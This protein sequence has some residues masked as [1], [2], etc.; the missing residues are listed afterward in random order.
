M[1]AANARL[2]AQDPAGASRILEAVTAR[3]PANGRAWRLLGIAYQRNKELDKAL[4][5]YR[6]DLEIEPGAPQTLYSM[7][8]AFALKQD[9]EQA[10]EWLGQAKASRK[11]DDTG[12]V[13]QL[14]AQA[15]NSRMS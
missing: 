4:A 9:A 12:C 14:G 10:F 2:Q 7:G 11:L 15:L 8:A 5:A 1:A 3:E 6:R 13:P